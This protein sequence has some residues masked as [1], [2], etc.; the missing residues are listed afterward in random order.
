MDILKVHINTYK[1]IFQKWERK[2]KNKT[3]KLLTV[4]WW[5]ENITKNKQ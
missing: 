3:S 5:I 1:N 2:I 4:K